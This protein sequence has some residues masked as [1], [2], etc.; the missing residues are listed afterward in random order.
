M[1][2][3]KYNPSLLKKIEDI[4]KEGGYT[5]RYEKGNFQNGYCILEKRRVVVINKFHELEAKINSMIEILLSVD[6][7]ETENLSSES[8]Q[9]LQQLKAEKTALFQ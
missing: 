5:V 4:F 7:L 3:L 6:D 2:N 9:L 8:L 1:S